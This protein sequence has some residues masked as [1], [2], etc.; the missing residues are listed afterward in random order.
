MFKQEMST[1]KRSEK[2]RIIKRMHNVEEYKKEKKLEEINEKMRRAEEF[3]YQKQLMLEKKKEISDEIERQKREVMEKF[4]KIMKKNKGIN[5]ETIRE[6]FPDDNELVEKIMSIKEI[7]ASKS[8][9]ITSE[10]STVLNNNLNKSQISNREKASNSNNN[11]L[12][13]KE[14]TKKVEDYKM[15]LNQQLAD[16]IN[17]EKEKEEER[18]RIYDR[19]QEPDKKKELESQ[20]SKERTQSTS[21]VMK[22]TTYNF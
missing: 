1:I 16:L 3:K 22:L 6:L 11:N 17:E 4:D 7:N 5:V 8:K 2:S 15:K 21:K 9:I 20:I 12:S 13:E 14:I 18:N 19:E 10:Q